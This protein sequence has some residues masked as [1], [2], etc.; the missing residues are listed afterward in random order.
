M[1]GFSIT[2]AQIR[3]VSADFLQKRRLFQI[4]DENAGFFHKPGGPAGFRHSELRSD[5]LIGAQN[6]LHKRLHHNPGI[7]RHNIPLPERI[8]H[9][10]SLRMDVLRVKFGQNRASH[11]LDVADLQ[12]GERNE[13]E[14]LNGD[15]FRQEQ[16]HEVNERHRRQKQDSPENAA[17]LDGDEHEVREGAG[18]DEESSVQIGGHR[19][20]GAALGAA[21]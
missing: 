1:V 9:F 21:F 12:S 15:G 10:P 2:E 13:H 4:A 11:R 8:K 20:A 6:R 17:C 14:R 7:R 19:L 16:V 18:G 5:D 3:R